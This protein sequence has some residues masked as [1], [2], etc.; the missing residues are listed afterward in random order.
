LKILDEATFSKLNYIAL[1][2]IKTV[3]LFI[4]SVPFLR[5]KYGVC[6]D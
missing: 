3:K 2:M 4:I 6:P 5:V 1:V